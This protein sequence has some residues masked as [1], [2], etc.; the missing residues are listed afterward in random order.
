MT[1]RKERHGFFQRLMPEFGIIVGT[2]E[3]TAA[4]YSDCVA[5]EQEILDLECQDCR[6]EIK[7]STTVPGMK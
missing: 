7:R 5:D 6:A 2:V 1:Y 3:V 4:R